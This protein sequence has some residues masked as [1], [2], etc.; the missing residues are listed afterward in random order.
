MTGQCRDRFCL[1]RRLWGV[2]CILMIAASWGDIIAAYQTPAAKAN[3]AGVE[4]PQQLAKSLGKSSPFQVNVG[5]PDDPRTWSGQPFDPETWQPLRRLVPTDCKDI[6]SITFRG[7]FDGPDGLPPEV[8]YRV[9]DEQI[10]LLSE[11][12]SLRCL[13]MIE[14]G[15]KPRHFEMLTSLSHLQVLYLRGCGV[16]D[17]GLQWIGQM[18]DLRALTL[19]GEPISAGGL[20][21][22]TGLSKLVSFGLSGTHVND[23]VVAVLSAL[24][25]I[26]FLRIGG[27]IS[28]AGLGALRTLDSLEVLELDTH[29]R[30]SVHGTGLKHLPA[31]TLRELSLPMAMSDEGLAAVN[32]FTQ[33]RKLDVSGSP[34]TDKGLQSLRDLHGLESLD[35]TSTKI[36]G[37]GLE[38]LVGLKRL[39]LT[40]AKIT[41]KNCASL[42]SLRALQYLSLSGTPVDGDCLKYL[43]GLQ[44][45]EELDAGSTR[46]TNESLQ[47]LDTLPSLRSLNVSGCSAIDDG[48]ARYLGKLVTLE[49]LTLVGTGITEAALPEFRGLTQLRSLYLPNVSGRI[50]QSEQLKKLRQALPKCDISY[51]PPGK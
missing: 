17:E 16:T 42:A 7:D 38:N 43:R 10:R 4:C 28:D 37:A 30:S 27:N 51:Y 26:R 2:I 33:L 11:V 31:G 32:R 44:H 21:H 18:K 20:R 39:S 48:A 1:A 19:A 25:S 3:A 13:Y 46:I 36:T 40:D 49:Q 15:L 29:S 50:G 45:L 6:V 23:D 22:L 47:H 14:A 35:A 24:K 41:A 34:V 5:D 12:K 9:N 8:P